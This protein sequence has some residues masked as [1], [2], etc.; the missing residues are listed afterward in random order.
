VLAVGGLSAGASTTA[1][2]APPSGNTRPA[3]PPTGATKPSVA[4]KV[5]ALSADDITIEEQSK[6]TA[7]VTYSGTTTFRT[8]TG[9][10]GASALKVGDFIAVQGATTSSGSVAATTI[11]IGGGPPGN[12]GHGPGGKGGGQRPAGKGGAPNGRGPTE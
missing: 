4:G 12:M 7:T 11:V 10:A 1:G 9:T 3:H 8:T 2:G 5:T 6:K